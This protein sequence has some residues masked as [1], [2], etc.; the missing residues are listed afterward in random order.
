MHMS[1]REPPYDGNTP[2]RRSRGHSVPRGVSLRR[3]A[4]FLLAA[5]AAQGLFCQEAVRTA[6]GRPASTSPNQPSESNGDERRVYAMATADYPVTPGDVYRLTYVYSS[7]VSSMSVSVD[8][9]YSV[10]LSQFGDVN[11]RG[12]TLVELRQ[13]VAK[14]VLARYPGSGPQLSVEAVGVF[15]VYVKGEVTAAGWVPAWGLSRLSGIVK[16]RLTPYSSIRDVEVAAGAAGATYDLFQASRFGRQELDPYVGPADTVVV[17]RR[18]RE[19]SVAGE[20]ER[21]GSFQLLTGDGLKE[22]LQV[23]GGGYT[24]LADAA[25]VQITRWDLRGATGETL[26]VDAESLPS[27]VELRDMDVVRVPSMKERLPVVYFE[28]AIASAGSPSSPGADTFSRVWY[29]FVDGELLSSAVSALYARFGSGSD[30]DHAFV[31]RGDTAEKI[32]VD[33]RRLVQDRGSSQDL[34]LRPFDRIV[35]P[36]RKFVV[37]VSGA[38]ARPGQYPYL[39]DRS[40]RYY[41]ELAGGFDPARHVGE[42]VVVTDAADRRQPAGRVIEAEDK[43]NVPTNNFFYTAAPVIQIVGVLA[44]VA[45]AIATILQLLK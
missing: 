22:L 37:T 1:V 39:P 7:E 28:G 36:F 16:D 35:I 45:T 9:Q 3:L 42:D 32:P 27:P 34:P 13:R 5:L 31:I 19:V 20:V 41:V 4:C 6:S 38:V 40:W 17:H 24:R 21:P 43:V 29:P 33:L 15:Q 44:A 30:I 23:Y 26:Y 14:T 11:A 2:R 12:L 25:H 18:S 8:S 10:N